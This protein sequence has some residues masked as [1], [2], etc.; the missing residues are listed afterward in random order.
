M[1]TEI[2]TESAQAKHHL[3]AKVGKNKKITQEIIT[4]GDPDGLGELNGKAFV[5]K[6]EATIT[7][8]EGLELKKALVKENEQPEV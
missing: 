5:V 3:V 1:L 7:I 2:R 6:S 8:E 4:D